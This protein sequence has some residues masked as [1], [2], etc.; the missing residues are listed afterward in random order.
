EHH[1]VAELGAG[2]ELAD[3]VRQRRDQLAGS[4]RAGRHA[5][6]GTS[7]MSPRRLVRGAR[8]LLAHVV[9]GAATHV[10]ASAMGP[11]PRAGKKVRAATMTTVPATST[12]NRGPSVGRVPAP[13]AT[14]RCPASE[15]ASA[16]VARIGTKRPNSMA[17]ARVDWKKS[18]VTVMPANALPLLLAA[19]A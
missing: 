18:L 2:V 7:G 14:R 9:Q 6:T 17:S 19:E 8:S 10:R 3:R 12:P 4:E 1:R 16:N 13:G 11:S 15:P 5:T